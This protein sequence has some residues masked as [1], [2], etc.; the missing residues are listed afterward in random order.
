MKPNALLDM[1]GV[2]VDL[3]GSWLELY[4]NTYCDRPGTVR[5][6]NDLITTYDFPNKMDLECTPEQMWGLLSTPGLFYNLK[7]NPGAVE[8]VTALSS[9][10]KVLIVTSAPWRASPNSGYE[11]Y[12]WCK[13]NLPQNS[14]ELI[15]T[16]DKSIIPGDFL[17]DDAP[18]NLD[19]YPGITIGTR[20]AYNRDARPSF[21][22]DS[23]D[24]VFKLLI[25]EDLFSEVK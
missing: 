25:E 3:L 14:Y 17:V 5:L 16:G 22:V 18:D 13:K 20:A 11:K 23:V 9:H 2:L 21:W 12:L 10:Y 1:D 15:I 24:Q 8:L 4:N 6:R 19:N 7:P